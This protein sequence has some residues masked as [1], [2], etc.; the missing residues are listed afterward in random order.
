MMSLAPVCLFVYNRIYQTRQT[1]SALQNNFLA[2]ESE[3]IIFSDGPK[4]EEDRK[5]VDAV[6]DYIKIVGGFKSV[7]LYQSNTK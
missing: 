4:N 6:R 2:K 1:I 5:L 7:V 3:L